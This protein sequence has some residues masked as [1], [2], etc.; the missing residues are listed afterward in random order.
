MANWF[1]SLLEE[2]IPMNKSVKRFD[3]LDT[4]TFPKRLVIKIVRLWCR[5]N[6]V[7]WWD[8]GRVQNVSFV[9]AMLYYM[10][11]ESIHIIWKSGECS[12]NHVR[13]IGFHMESAIQWPSLTKNPTMYTSDVCSFLYLPYNLIQILKLLLFHTKQTW[14]LR[15]LKEVN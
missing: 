1:W 10:W 3:L 4:G 9:T 13:R 11:K 2:T 12:K 7:Y 14:K 5:N 6:Q 15:Y 8:R